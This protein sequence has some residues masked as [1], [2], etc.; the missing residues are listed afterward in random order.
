VLVGLFLLF[1]AEFTCIA[2]EVVEFPPGY[3]PLALA[4]SRTQIDN[5][6]AVIPSQCYTKTDGIS[7]P[8]YTCH[9]SFN[10]RNEMDDDDLQREYA[11]SDFALENHW[12][13]LFVD[14]SAVIA[15]IGD[16][17]VLEY[18]RQ[19]NYT[20]LKEHLED[21]ADYA[22]WV[23]DLED[24]ATARGIAFDPEGFARD[25]S[26]WRAFRYK[27]FLGTF[28]PTNGSTDDVIIRLAPEFY[29]DSAGR[30][31]REIY[32]VNLAIL[33]AAI[34]TPNT[35]PLN[36]LNREVEPIDE[37]LAGVDLD[38]DGVLRT[39][40]TRI[41]R[42]PAYYVGA[43]SDVPVQRFLYPQGTEFLH[44]VRYVDPDRTDMVSSRMKE[45][46]YS[47]RELPIS[48]DKLRRVYAAEFENKEQGNLP[49][50]GGAG[51]TGLV[52]D[53]GWRLQGFIE[54]AQGHLRA[55]TNEETLFCMGC[56]STIGVTADQTFAFPRKVPGE[57]GW[58]YQKLDGIQDVPQTGH[59][60][61]ETLE[62]FQRVKGGDEF[63]ANEEALSR[64]FVNG[65]VKEAEVR[66][67]APGGELDIRHLVFPSRARAL[68]LNKA[69]MAL[70]REQRFELGRDA[71]AEP[72]TR[73]F[74]QIE[75]N[76]TT[77]LG[78]AG[79]LFEDGRIWLDWE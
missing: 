65:V 71:V 63:R 28:W 56:H 64:F 47:R 66:R 1:G 67:A 46:R 45:V 26:W 44:T 4:R 53:F 69:Y 68:D 10:G 32:K 55:Q 39:S 38:G 57:R 76:G 42:L 3:D 40:V 79:L 20:A 6:E 49:V 23:P 29:R 7:N 37:T 30:E 21:R 43:A 13:N 61:P 58:G 14:R 22:G 34:A 70:V 77:A 54:S 78:D 15:S 17:E 19:D 60:T 12:T 16:A 9:T 73:V 59:D 11:F 41:Q 74:R 62:Y 18:I 2:P 35:R 33:E 27:P 25:G 5:R 50:Y 36:A 48:L 75:G 8:C 52:N 31:S 24:L 72:A 51:E